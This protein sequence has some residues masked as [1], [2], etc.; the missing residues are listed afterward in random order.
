M[1]STHKSTFGLLLRRY[2]VAA[3]LTQEELA[4]RAGLSAHGISNLERGVRR[5]PQRYT[6]TQ[7]AE[8]LRL[9]AE[10]R[11]HLEAA[12][13]SFGGS[14]VPA[15]TETH[16]DVVTGGDWPP[17]AD[18]TRA[19]ARADRPAPERGRTAATPAGR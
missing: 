15:V 3:G 4:E 11:A 12:A 2:R 16:R 9:S 6:L 19:R 1:S 14:A 8:A 18:R 10:D 7:L 5:A 17:T 13:R